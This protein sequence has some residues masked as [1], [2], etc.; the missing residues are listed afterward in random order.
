M[1]RQRS[2]D[3]MHALT[4]W[5]VPSLVYLLVAGT[6][7]G[8]SG[9][10][11]NGSSPLQ[12]RSPSCSAL[13]T[14]VASAPKVP[15]TPLAGTIHQTY[16]LTLLILP[17]QESFNSSNALK[18]TWC[19]EPGSP[20]N[21][22]EPTREVLSVHLIGPYPSKAAANS[23]NLASALAPPPHVLA[24]SGPMLVSTAPLHTNSWND[25]VLSLTL[26]LP[27]NLKTGYYIV[28]SENEVTL[29][30]AATSG[31]GTIDVIGFGGRVIAVT[32]SPILH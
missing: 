23:A 4:R 9:S 16:T 26:T 6:V 1:R 28:W 13:S 10:S 17:P 25:A 15:Q 21:A 29:P 8:C 22:T 2:H 14:A 27:S 7:G 5:L 31:Q 32:D 3:P 30:P 20:T 12:V 19:P 24:P 18:I 11:T